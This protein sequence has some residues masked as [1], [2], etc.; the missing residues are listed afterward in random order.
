MSARTAVAITG[1]GAAT[2]LGADASTFRAG[3]LE[4]RH[5]F[6][7]VSRFD[8]TRYGV[9]W[10]GQL[11]DAVWAPPGSPD[12]GSRPA[13]LLD[14]VAAE[15]LAMAGGPNDT[16]TALVLGT[17]LGS[18]ELSRVAWQEQHGHAPDYDT[19]LSG[20]A[21]CAGR[22]LVDRLALGG[23][24]WSVVTAC[25]AGT[26][27]IGV[28]ADLIRLG[29]VDRVLAGG[30]DTL[31]ELIYAGFDSMGA[32]GHDCRPFA[33]DREGVVLA[34]GAAMIVLDSEGRARGRGAHIQAWVLGC[35]TAN[36]AY[37]ATAPHPDGRGAA[38]AMQRCLSD[39]GLSPADIDYVNAH[40][41]GTH[42]NDPAE[43]AAIAAVL[44][45]HA[46]EIPVSSTKSQ[47]GHALSAAGAIEAVA[48]VLALRD[49]FV[50]PT[51][52]RH[53]PLAAAVG[54]DFVQ[55]AG[56][57]RPMACALSNSFAFGGH[58]A[59]LALGRADID[60]NSERSGGHPALRS[61]SPDPT[62]HRG[63]R[64]AHSR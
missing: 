3:L 47:M 50:P 31:T 9:N 56:R 48:T 15:A 64:A 27:A 7:P 6:G 42:A 19:V 16:R 28:G 62:R 51:A 41:T 43:W 13:Q 34:E 17:T 20:M 29:L 38:L 14:R 61:P 58:T 60:W 57:R 37:H 25:A 55:D 45:S 18:D 2:P 10:A 46:W 59:C 5:G 11:D 40:G 52:H 32:L 44:G 8:A 30:V 53:A 39:A 49:G 26:T 21:D 4:G 12:A 22:R 63:V 24:V 35:G 36:D 1:L 54:A 23:P 33:E